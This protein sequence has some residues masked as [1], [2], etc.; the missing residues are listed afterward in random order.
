MKL[1]IVRK[2][3]YQNEMF[4]NPLRLLAKFKKYDM[5]TGNFVAS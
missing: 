4:K 5:L 3:E 2:L 1:M